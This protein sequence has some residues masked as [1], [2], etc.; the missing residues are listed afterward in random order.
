M[1]RSI[2]LV[3]VF[4][5]VLVSAASVF[6]QGMGNDRPD[7]GELAA[8]CVAHMEHVA[9]QTTRVI[10]H[11]T[12]ETV[13]RI[14]HLDRAGAS[15]DEIIAAGRRGARA[16]ANVAMRGSGRVTHVERHCV[17]VL[18]RLGAERDLI[19]RVRA[20][21]EGFREAIGTAAR[22]GV[23]VIRSAVAHAIG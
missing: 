18:I 15:D 14:V 5:A 7:P 16:V 13:A 6:G 12:D 20:Q 22:R 4:A 23:G 1:S 21:A 2:T 10:G 8:R 3:S 17:R 11:V 9:D 19:M